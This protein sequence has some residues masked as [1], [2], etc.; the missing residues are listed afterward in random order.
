MV[1]RRISPDLKNC[2]L[3][4]W[5]RGWDRSDIC[6][7]LGISSA[8]LYRWIQ[9]FNEFDSVVKPPSPLRGRPRMITLAAL[10]AMKEI[11]NHHPDSYLDEL[12]WFLALHHDVVISKSALHD[13]LRKAGLTRKLMRKIAQERDEDER[14]L[15]RRYGYAMKGQRAEINAPF[16]RGQRYSLVAAMSL[17]G[18]IAMRVVEGSL[19]SF[20]FFDFIIDEV[21]PQMKPFPDQHSVLVMDNYRIHHS[22]MLLESCNAL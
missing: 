2:A 14:T 16:V 15:T 11:Y 21:L 8:S 7:A 9:I 10:T 20:E 12:V 17:E 18:Y 3:D 13:N 19:D 5:E 6:S 22:D 1:N 4:L